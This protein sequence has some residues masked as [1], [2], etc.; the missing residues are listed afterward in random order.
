MEP[1]VIFKAG[2][3]V[4]RKDGNT[5]SNGKKVATI[6]G[7]KPECGDRF[8]LM[9]T[10]SH[11]AGRNLELVSSP[12]VSDGG[13][14]SYYDLPEGASELNDLIEAKGMS[15]ARGNIFKACY[16][17]GEKAGTDA[18]YDINKIIYFAERLR[19]VIEKGQKP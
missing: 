14:S 5:F 7:D 2:D 11:V 10:D 16:R 8:Y 19:G 4:R 6:R 9:E 3:R 15:F 12:V 17:L 1:D 18:L 13:S